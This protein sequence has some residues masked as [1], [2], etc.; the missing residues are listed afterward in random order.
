MVL[1]ITRQ[2][3]GN[4][5]DLERTAGIH[6]YGAETNYTLSKF[7]DSIVSQNKNV[8]GIAVAIVI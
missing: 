1:K 7:S 6:T 5:D 3:Y 4:T 2:Q 8:F